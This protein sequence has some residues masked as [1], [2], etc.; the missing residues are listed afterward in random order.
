MAKKLSR[1]SRLFLEMDLFQALP[2]LYTVQLSDWVMECSISYILVLYVH[3]VQYIQTANYFEYTFFIL[4][5]KPIL[6]II[7]RLFWSNKL[8][9]YL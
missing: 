7:V 4:T 3:I 5:V 1:L 2:A 8:C 9:F 6:K